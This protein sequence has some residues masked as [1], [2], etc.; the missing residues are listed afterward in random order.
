MKENQKF[1]APAEPAT[2]Q[3]SFTT[4]FSL[5][6]PGLE[7]PMDFLKVPIVLKKQNSNN[8][9]NTQY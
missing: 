9:K 3:V 7:H 2:F 4:Q 6:Q 1:I 8:K 5:V